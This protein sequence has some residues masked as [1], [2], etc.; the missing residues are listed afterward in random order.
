M[1]WQPH[2]TVAAVIEREQKYLLVE[3]HADGH[4]VFNQ[5]AGHWE[6]GESL[7]EAAVR[8]TLEETGWE[9]RP[10]ALVGIY[11][12][13]HP[14]KLE[15]FLRFTFCGHVNTER[16]STNLDEGIISAD[17]YSAKEILALPEEKIRS[18]MVTHSLNDYIEGKRYDLSLIKDIEQ[19]W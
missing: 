3:E 1:S 4:V 13:Q 10:S 2:V 8:E 14:K 9:F 19:Y 16:T 18:T 11:R 5:P 6:P 15:T 17:W 7:I 12:W